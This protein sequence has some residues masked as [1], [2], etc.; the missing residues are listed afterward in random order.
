MLKYSNMESPSPKGWGFQ[1][2]GTPF[3]I[4]NFHSRLQGGV[5]NRLSCKIILIT[6]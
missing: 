3:N 5:F 2:K 6:A 4:V 1:A